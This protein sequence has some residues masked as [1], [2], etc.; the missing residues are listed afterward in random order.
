METTTAYIDELI[1]TL[2]T[3]PATVQRLALTIAWNDGDP[4]PHP[5]DYERAEDRVATILATCKEYG[6]SLADIT[7]LADKCWGANR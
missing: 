5:E 6:A 2:S 1:D 3:I 4:H 7:N